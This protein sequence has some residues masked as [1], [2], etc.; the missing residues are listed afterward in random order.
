MNLFFQY[1]STYKVN[2]DTTVLKPNRPFLRVAGMTA[3][4]SRHAG[5]SGNAHKPFVGQAVGGGIQA[6][7]AV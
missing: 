1:I 4:Y 5:G 6:C 2:H 7:G 3:R